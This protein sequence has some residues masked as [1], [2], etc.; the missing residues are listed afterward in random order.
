MTITWK[1]QTFTM[2][3]EDGNYWVT[4]PAGQ[5]APMGINITKEQA[6]ERF[7]HLTYTFVYG[8]VGRIF[9]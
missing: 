2:F 8:S 6:L 5:M 9:T 4:F 1:D 3:I 7:F